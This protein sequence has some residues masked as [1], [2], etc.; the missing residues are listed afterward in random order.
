M[1]LIYKLT[2]IS[3]AILFISAIAT[4]IMNPISLHREKTIYFS[5]N[6]DI[7]IFITGI[8]FAVFILLLIIS[9]IIHSIDQKNNSTEGSD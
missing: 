4:L 7:A 3:G 2:A 8:I 1:K 5:H 9:L 6:G